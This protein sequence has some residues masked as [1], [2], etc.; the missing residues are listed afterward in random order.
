MAANEFFLLNAF[1]GDNALGNQACVMFVDSLDDTAA[2]QRLA[3]DFNMP[4]TTF[5]TP[6]RGGFNVRW[7]APDQEIELCGHGT[8]AATWVLTQIMG[9]P[10]PIRYNCSLGEI[11]GEKEGDR[12]VIQADAIPCMASAIPEAV[13]KGFHYKPTAYY[14]SAN[15][16]LVLFSSEE[17]VRSMKPDWDTLRT[18][19][20][21]SYAITAP[22]ATGPYDFVSRVILPHISAL[23]DQATGS[24]HLVLAPF[25]GA[26][27]GKTQLHAFQASARGGEMHCT[28]IEGRVRLSARCR[29]FAHGKLIS[30]P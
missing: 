26:R 4:A 28:L 13:L 14:V 24:A 18:S 7:F 15:K 10:A 11:S 1:T 27:L 19:D 20:T 2:L 9:K 5:L 12:V 22:S 8:V 25:W 21:F 3:A 16:H 29:P 6:H 30:T 23:E 17:E